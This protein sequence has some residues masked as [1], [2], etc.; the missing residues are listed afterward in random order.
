VPTPK[1]HQS[2]T[3]DQVEA[4]ERFVEAPFTDPPAATAEQL[5]AADSEVVVEVPAA[6]VLRMPE[7]HGGPADPEAV[8]MLRERLN[9]AT[10]GV[11][12]WQ[13]LW[14]QEGDDAGLAWRMG[15]G[16]SI[17]D[18]SFQVSLAGWWLGKLLEQSGA[19]TGGEEDVRRI[20]ATV[21]GDEAQFVTSPIGAVLGSLTLD[22]A[23]MAVTLAENAFEGNIRITAAGRMEV[24]S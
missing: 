12:A 23:A 16:S 22:E 17:S 19:E 14:R 4:V 18:R 9:R 1:E 24:A 5:D 20:L 13:N 3:L 10:K 6:P 21:V 7:N 2:W 11:R 15:R 8:K